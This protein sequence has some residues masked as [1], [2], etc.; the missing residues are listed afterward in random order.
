MQRNHDMV[1]ATGHGQQ[2]HG[3]DSV[4]HR[5]LRFGD[6]APEPFVVRGG[7]R[8]TEKWAVSDK[9]IGEQVHCLIPEHVIAAAH[10]VPPGS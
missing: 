10:D 5:D 6:R 8:S 3:K 4:R 7:G 9:P 2:H 1:R